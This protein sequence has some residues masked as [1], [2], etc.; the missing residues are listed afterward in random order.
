MTT[1]GIASGLAVDGVAGPFPRYASNETLAELREFFMR[2]LD[3]QP[4]HP[5]YGEYSVRDWHLVSPSV[6]DLLS[7][8]ELVAT[9]EAVTGASNLILWRSKLFEK[10]PNDGPIDWHQEYGYFDGE[11]AGGHRPALYPSGPESPWNWTVWLPLT[12]VTEHDGVME[13][14]RGSHHRRYSTRM[15]PI[16]RSGAFVDPANRITSKDELVARAQANSLIVDVDTR[17]AFDTMDI[18]HCTLDDL[19]AALYAHCDRTQAVVTEPFELA[20]GQSVITP[21]QTGE[22]IVF[23]ERCMHRSRGAAPDATTRLALSARYTVGSTWV[24]PQRTAGETLDGSGL[25]ISP[26]ACIRVAGDTFNP[27]NVYRD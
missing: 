5:L 9:L 26:H 27:N 13:F 23:S 22:Y 8:P 25:D 18:E 10:F 12:D 6:L 3:E 17:T 4:I 1:S 14:V 2:L 7:A 16:T 24:Y 21:M 20:P 19:L 11:E 15:V